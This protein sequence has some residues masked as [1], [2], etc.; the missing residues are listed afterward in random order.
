MRA[1]QNEKRESRV[2]CGRSEQAESGTR[3]ARLKTT[4][5]GEVE[6]FDGSKSRRRRGRDITSRTKEKKK[7]ELATVDGGRKRARDKQ[8]TALCDSRRVQA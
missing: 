4:P 3:C 2:E 1:Q 5:G 6:G 7:V 8:A